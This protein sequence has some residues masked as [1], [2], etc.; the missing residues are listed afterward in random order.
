MSKAKFLNILVFA[1][2]F[3]PAADSESDIIFDNEDDNGK[4]PVTV[5]IKL[6]ATESAYVSILLLQNCVLLD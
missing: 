4:S 3:R 5:N 2:Q 1:C 6:F